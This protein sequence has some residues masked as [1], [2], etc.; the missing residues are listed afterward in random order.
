MDH[1][2][3]L[4][5]SFVATSYNFKRQERHG[6]I[7]RSGLTFHA[8]NRKLQPGAAMV[9][10][11]S[12]MN[13]RIVTLPSV[14]L[15]Q[16]QHVLLLGLRHVARRA[17]APYNQR[18]SPLTICTARPRRQD[19][20]LAS[21]KV[22]CGCLWLDGDFVSWIEQ[23][24]DKLVLQVPESDPTPFFEPLLRSFVLGLGTGALFEATHV[25]WKVCFRWRPTSF[26]GPV[27][28]TQQCFMF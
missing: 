9:V 10:K 13:T 16:S 14:R 18:H 8:G 17:L 26:A 7:C 24:T 12:V 3:Q 21:R 22:S 4:I 28:A 27:R 20:Q 2:R 6:R 15:C 19:T 23:C 25:S 1:V 11:A 5:G